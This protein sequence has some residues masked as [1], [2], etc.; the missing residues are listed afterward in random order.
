MVGSP[1]GTAVGWGR[2]TGVLS[3]ALTIELA[4]LA[5]AG[6][7]TDRP[8]LWLR[9]AADATAN[10]DPWF[11]DGLI[12]AHQ[13]RSTYEYRGP[14]RRLQLTLDI[15]GK[16]AWA[17]KELAPVDPAL[18][19]GRRRPRPTPGRTSSSASRTSGP[20]RCGPIAAPGASW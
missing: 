15:L 20:P 7:H 2:S 16:L 13:H 11:R 12:T 8:G 14:F 1:D 5:V 19:A 4:A 6:G 17:A 3:A 18:V 9:R 10:L